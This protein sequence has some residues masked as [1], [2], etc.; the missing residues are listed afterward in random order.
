MYLV[1][2]LILS[3]FSL[4]GVLLRFAVFGGQKVRQDL[5]LVQNLHTSVLYRFLNVFALVLSHSVRPLSP[6]QG[7]KLI[8][9]QHRLKQ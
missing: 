3:H 4:R 9:L 6:G 5:F 1:G 7:R 2:T 8:T